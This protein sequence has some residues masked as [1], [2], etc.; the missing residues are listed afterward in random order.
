MPWIHR[1]SAKK[2]KKAIWIS[3]PL[4]HLCEKSCSG[5]CRYAHK[6]RKAR[7][8]VS[9]SGSVCCA[10]SKRNQPQTRRNC[11]EQ[12]NATSPAAYGGKPGYF[13]P[14]CTIRNTISGDAA[15]IPVLI[16]SRVKTLADSGKQLN[17]YAFSLGAN[18]EFSGF[19]SLARN[20]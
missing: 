13:C 7:E 5:F 6:E 16:D 11:H 2:D 12:R 14:R 1:T 9:L 8:Q 18:N 20:P 19:A 3:R 15:T 10:V 4:H 17:D